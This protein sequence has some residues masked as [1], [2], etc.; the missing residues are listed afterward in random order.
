MT[1]TV[2]TEDIIYVGEYHEVTNF[3]RS[4]GT[5]K[6]VKLYDA[7]PVY[8]GTQVIG[9]IRRYPDGS[10]QANAGDGENFKW[11]INSEDAERPSLSFSS[12]VLALLAVGMHRN[13]TSK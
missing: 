1:E 6:L 11:L 10:Y 12:E 5:L 2:H 8:A 7:A 4:G 9:Q 13:E 3:K